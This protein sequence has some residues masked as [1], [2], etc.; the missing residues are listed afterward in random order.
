MP[1]ITRRTISSTTSSGTVGVTSPKTATQLRVS[2]LLMP[3][4]HATRAI[5]VL[6]SAQSR[7]ASEIW[8]HILSGWPSVTLSLLK[9]R[10]ACDSNVLLV[11]ADLLL[12]L[13]SGELTCRELRLERGR[14]PRSW[15]AVWPGRSLPANAAGHNRD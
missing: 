5:G 3:D 9:S 12:V 14:C 8:S 15:R 10:C 4:S 11:K 6:D 1:V 2:S 13:L 7:M